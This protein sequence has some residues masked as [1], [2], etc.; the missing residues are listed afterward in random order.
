MS[1]LTIY[2]YLLL[3]F[4]IKPICLKKLLPSL[5]VKFRESC[6]FVDTYGNL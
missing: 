1:K 6:Q 2:I 5:W 3:L 4:T